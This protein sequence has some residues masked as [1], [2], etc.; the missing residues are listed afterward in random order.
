ML[1]NDN[2]FQIRLNRLGVLGTQIT[3]TV[4]VDLSLLL[5]PQLTWVQTQQS[6]LTWISAVELRTERNAMTKNRTSKPMFTRKEALEAVSKTA[7]RTQRK[8]ARFADNGWYHGKEWTHQ[9]LLANELRKHLP[10]DLVH[11]GAIVGKPPSVNANKKSRKRSGMDI[12]VWPN[13]D[14]FSCFGSR[15]ETEFQPAVAI[16][17]K[18]HYKGHGFG[19]QSW[20]NDILRLRAMSTKVLKFAILVDLKDCRVVHQR[21]TIRTPKRKLIEL[22]P[23]NCN[24]E[25]HFRKI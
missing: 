9:N 18:S 17:I 5:R 8:L 3:R 20:A 13:K 7:E 6:C 1:T 21:I 19:T 12:V 14:V 11:V 4:K 25:K 23:G 2:L 10:S 15:S 22:F 24:P 16:E